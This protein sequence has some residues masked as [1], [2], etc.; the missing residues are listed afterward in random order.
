MNTVL[1]TITPGDLIEYEGLT[2]YVE[3]KRP[4][5]RSDEHGY[6]YEIKLCTSRGKSQ[7][8]TGYD[9]SR[10]I[11]RSRYDTWGEF[12]RSGLTDR[13]ISPIFEAPYS[14]LGRIPGDS[15]SFMLDP[16]ALGYPEDGDD[17]LPP[18]YKLLDVLDIRT[19]KPVRFTDD[20]RYWVDEVEFVGPRSILYV[21]RLTPDET[22][23]LLDN[24]GEGSDD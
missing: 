14:L 10:C 4:L 3:S 17:G 13:I 18:S 23:E 22:V 19:E 8:I 11:R 5:D 16:L 2:G 15:I 12:K 21:R 20:A 7:K 6:H 24:L 1:S 9:D